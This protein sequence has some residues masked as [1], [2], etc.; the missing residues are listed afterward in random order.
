MGSFSWE[1]LYLCLLPTPNCRSRKR[2]TILTEM[3]LLE[4]WK[5]QMFLI[6]FARRKDQEEIKR[7][8]TKPT[9]GYLTSNPV[10][11]CATQL[12][13]ISGWAS[14]TS[15]KQGMQPQH[16][17]STTVQFHRTGPVGRLCHTLPRSFS[18][19]RTTCCEHEEHISTAELGSDS[20]SC[21]WFQTRPWRALQAPAP[22]ALKKPLWE[23]S[24]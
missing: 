19:L 22:R 14:V 13:L 10:F 8:Q 12:F 5:Q 7:P 9:K 20:S 3:A 6:P 2:F 17:R 23:I 1:T 4:K 24:L 11:S 21:H 16:N 15:T 18:W